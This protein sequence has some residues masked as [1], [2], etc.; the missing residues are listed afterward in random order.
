MKS[1]RLKMVMPEAK[2]FE[3]ARLPYPSDAPSVVCIFI[4]LIIGVTALSSSFPSTGSSPLPGRL[5]DPKIVAIC[6]D[7]AGIRSA[8]QGT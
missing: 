4:A 7:N 2:L 3:T 8:K 6:K 1:D 5:H